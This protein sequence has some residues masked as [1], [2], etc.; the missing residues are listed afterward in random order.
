M[1][2]KLLKLYNF[3]DFEKYSLKN[4]CD[5]WH[6]ILFPGTGEILQHTQNEV[7]LA[8]AGV[9]KVD[10][11][12]ESIC[13]SPESRTNWF[14]NRNWIFNLRTDSILQYNDVNFVDFCWKKFRK[15]KSKLFYLICDLQIWL[16]NFICKSNRFFVIWFGNQFDLWID[17]ICE[18][19][20]FD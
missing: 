15:N 16:I 17:F 14:T 5:F 7:G 11:K 1:F 18:P 9:E 8:V 6:I 12:Q 13:N 4:M 20:W 2:R 19:Y 3:L 10:W